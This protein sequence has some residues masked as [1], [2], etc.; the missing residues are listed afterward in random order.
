AREQVPGAVAAHRQA[1]EVDAALVDAVLLAQRLDQAED[2]GGGLGGPRGEGGGLGCPG[3][4]GPGLPGGALRRDEEARVLLA[5]RLAGEIGDAVLEL[6]LVVAAAL[7]GAVE[8]DDEGE[9]VL[10]VLLVAGR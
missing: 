8:E 10:A 5:R 2:E 7:A 3:D 9:G 1:G 4:V 6:G